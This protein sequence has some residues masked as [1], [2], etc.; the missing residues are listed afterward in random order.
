[1][2]YTD[3]MFL[4]FF[5]SVYYLVFWF[6]CKSKIWFMCN[7]TLNKKITIQASNSLYSSAF[8]Y[9][10][11]VSFFF[12]GGG[13]GGWGVISTHVVVVVIVIVKLPVI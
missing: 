1:M 11:F 12:W 4:F 5:L 7:K 3:P 13:G 10:I 6:S 8:L 2:L 9:L